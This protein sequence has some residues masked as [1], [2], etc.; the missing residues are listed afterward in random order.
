MTGKAMTLPEACSIEHVSSQA[1]RGVGVRFM[2]KY[3]PDAPSG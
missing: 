1:G 2:K 3:G